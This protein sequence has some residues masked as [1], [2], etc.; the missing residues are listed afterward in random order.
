VKIFEREDLFQEHGS[1]HAAI[2]VNQRE[3]AARFSSKNVRR[4]RQHRGDAAARREGHI[5][6]LALGAD[7][8]PKAPHRRTDVEQVARTQRV[9]EFAGHPAARLQ[10]NAQFEYAAAGRRDNGISA[11]LLASGDH[12]PYGDVLSRMKDERLT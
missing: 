7:R 12:A 2:A 3:T 1:R 9:A 11:P 8:G 6:K 4:K 5:G 10:P